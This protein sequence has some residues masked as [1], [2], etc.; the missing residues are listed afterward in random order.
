MKLYGVT[1]K[2]LQLGISADLHILEQATSF[3]LITLFIKQ[4]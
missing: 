4:G 3:L 1:G 2:N